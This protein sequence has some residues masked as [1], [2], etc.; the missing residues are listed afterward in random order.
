MGLTRKST[1][2]PSLQKRET[3]VEMSVPYW[4]GDN[5]VTEISN[6]I[7]T[8]IN[9]SNV[10]VNIVPTVISA[11]ARFANP[12][13]TEVTHGTLSN[14]PPGLYMGTYAFNTDING[15]G[16]WQTNDTMEYYFGAGANQG[17]YNVVQP[18]YRKTQD[19][20]DDV[21]ITGAAVFSNAATQNITIKSYYN[22]VTSASAGVSTTCLYATVQKV[23]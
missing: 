8:F 21:Y 16:V 5:E 22:Y 17:V 6:T 19:S 14:A 2:R 11:N 9:G 7:Q 23:G 13:R 18:F 15:A 3:L 10:A 4:L 12:G 1:I 20:G